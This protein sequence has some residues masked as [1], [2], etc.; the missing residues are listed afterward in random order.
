MAE[1]LFGLF[2][3]LMFMIFPFGII[4]VVLYLAYQMQK[5]RREAWAQL[6]AKMGLQ[7]SGDQVWGTVEGQGVQCRIVIKGSGKN[8]QTWTVI[9]NKIH[10]P[11]DLG[12]SVSRQ[13]VIFE[14]V[15]KLFDA[16]DHEIGDLTFDKAFVIKGDEVSR[17]KAL[18]TDDLRN[19]LLEIQ[20]LGQ[21][22]TL[23]DRGISIAMRGSIT[24]INRLEYCLQAVARGANL[25]RAT[26]DQVPIASPLKPHYEAWASF[27]RANG[28][29]G[30]TT[31]FLMWGEID[32]VQVSVFALRSGRLNYSAQVQVHFPEDLRH[33]LLVR[34]AGSLDALSALF[35]GQDHKVG[36]AEFDK[37]FVIQT[38]ST[39]RLGEILDEP[40]RKTLMQIKKSVGSVEVSDQGVS[41]TTPGFPREPSG[42]PQLIN[43]VKDVSSQIYRNAKQIYAVQIGPYR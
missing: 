13:N 11:L 6:A 27:A 25:V 14:V 21:S 42:V 29:Q 40:V 33:G 16:E 39:D 2:F 18:L 28:L 5:K 17:I 1:S 8:K 20:N 31:P 43:T 3:L 19:F 7:H 36:D 38:Y 22:V 26:R 32:G 9:S 15:G 4:G 34:P 37:A 23:N 24:D 35:G 12:L 41:V 10:P 30:I